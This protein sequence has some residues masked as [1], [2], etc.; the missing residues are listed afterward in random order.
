[1]THRYSGFQPRGFYIQPLYLLIV[2]GG[3][4]NQNLAQAQD[5][6]KISGLAYLDYS[7]TLASPVEAEVGTNGF[8][9][10]R[11]YLT[12]DYSLSQTFS[13]R[14]RLEAADNSTTAQGKPAPFVKDLYLKWKNIFSGVHELVIG[15]SS[16]PTYTVSE[17]VWGYRSLEKTIMDRNNVVSSRD[18][19]VALRGNLVSDGTV[20]YG[21]MA[22]NN[23]SVKGETD[24]HKRLY[25]QLEWRPTETLTVTA[26][27][28]YADYGDDRD[29]G[30]NGNG[31][32]GYESEKFRVGVE[33]FY[34]VF[35]LENGET[36]NLFGTTLFA[37]TQ[38]D[39]KWELIARV[40]QVDRSIGGV[41]TG[42]LYVLAG[43]AHT[44]HSKV[45][46]IPNVVIVKDRDEDTPQV[47]GRI[48]VHVNF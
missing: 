29:N 38:L 40:D 33:G 12:T 21:L 9:Y 1:M 23:S 44:P 5:H 2:I 20:R 24:K 39:E 31:F 11:L 42:D 15:V 28:D 41:E 4:I 35:N 6:I 19:G 3:F 36:D 37:A 47:E 32:I 45:F 30:V 27:G 26:G 34:N 48:T 7:Y 8:G 46:V 13:G 14:A 17:D 22:A 18:F 43:I 16:P 25:G 10:R